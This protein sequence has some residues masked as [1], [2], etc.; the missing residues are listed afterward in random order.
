M[1][2]MDQIRVLLVGGP[3][4]LPGAD[5]VQE[6]STMAES[7]KVPIGTGWDHFRYSGNC[8]D[9]HGSRLPVY[10]WCYRTKIAE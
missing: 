6:V 9:L 10:E 3:I 2:E 4:D 1:I 5:C 8:R 7:I